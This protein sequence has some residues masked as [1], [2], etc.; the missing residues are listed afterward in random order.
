MHKNALIIFVKNPVA[1]MVKT[2]LA[3][4]S[5]IDQALEI[6][7]QLLNY[8]LQICKKLSNC[9]KYVFYSDK[10]DTG[11]AWAKNGFHQRLQKGT[12]LGK[13]MSRAFEEVF[14]LGHKNCIIIGSDC[15]QINTIHLDTAF[16]K[17]DNHDA[18]IGPAND[19]GYYLLG[20]KKQHRTLFENKK[21]SSTSVFLDTLKDLKALQ[22]KTYIL[23]ELIDIDTMEDYIAFQQIQEDSKTGMA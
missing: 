8:T 15:P 11:D 22:L 12:D 6:Y 20:M 23:P 14:S 19:G 1:G 10:I 18:V 13:R 17:L 16:E 5:S 7:L 3:E 21:W 2:R 9:E 4:G